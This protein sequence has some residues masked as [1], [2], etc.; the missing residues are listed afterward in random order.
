[1]ERQREELDAYAHT[2]AHDLKA[3]LQSIMIYAHLL[4]HDD[5]LSDEERRDCA[6]GVIRTGLQMARIIDELLLLAAIRQ[7]EV[8]LEPVEMA[9]VVAGVLQRLGLQI[10]KSRAT[11]S[12]PDAWPV[13]LGHAPWVQEVWMNYLG[14]ALKYGGKPPR[15]EL[16]A[17]PHPDGMVRFWV[18]DNGRGLTREERERLFIPHTRLDT[19]TSEGHGLGLSI[20]RRIVEKLGGCVGVDSARGEG[21]TFFFTLPAATY[22]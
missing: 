5:L 13:A 7:R 20:V 2:V 14:N 15:M 4:D 1:M 11:I 6:E 17:A 22:S 18:K 8:D 9:P 21:S 19:T 3:P 12:L 16:G 10:E